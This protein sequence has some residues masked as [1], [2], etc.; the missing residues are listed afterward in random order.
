MPRSMTAR[1]E[2]DEIPFSIV[3]QLA[4]RVDVV[5]LKL[6]RCPAVLAAPPVARKYF[7]AELTIRLGFKP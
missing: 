1:A 5:D 4:S 2:R 6:L 7:A 3:S